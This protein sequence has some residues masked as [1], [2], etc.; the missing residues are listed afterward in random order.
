MATSSGWWMYHGDPAHTGYV[1]SGSAIDAAALSGGK[2]G[3]LHTLNVGGSILSVPAVSDGFIY[4]GLANSRDFPGEQ[5]GTLLKIDLKSG[6]TVKRFPWKVELN[7]RDTHGFCGMGS[8]PTVLGDGKTGKVYFVG[9]NAKLYC[10]TTADLSLVWVTDLRNRDLKHNQPVKTFEPGTDINNEPPPAAGWSAPLVVNGRIYLGIGEGENPQLNSFVFCLDAAT[11]NVVWVFCTNQ[12]VCGQINQPNQ[13]PE[14]VVRDIT[15]PPGYTVYYG[16][17]LTLGCSVWGCIAYDEKLNR[18]FCPTGNGVPDGRLPTPGWSNGLL[19][20]DATT[21]AF[22]AFYQIPRGSNYRDSDIDVD[23]GA[24]PTLF[25]LDGRRVVGVG[26]KNGSFHLLDADT[27]APIKCR[28]LLPTYNDGTQIPTVDPHP[29]KK[30]TDTNVQ[31]PR[32]AN[33]RSDLDDGEN[34]SGIYSTAAIHPGSR[35]IFVGIG[36]N[37]YHPVAAGIDTD[38]TPFIRALDYNTLDDAWPVD[39]GNPPRYAKGRP[40]LYTNSSESGLSSPAVVND[41]VFMATTYVSLYA[42]SVSDGTLLF[43]DRLGEQTGGFNGGYGYC[44]G[45]AVCGNYV[46]AGA[47]VFGGDGGVLRIYGITDGSGGVST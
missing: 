13:L 32:I 47:L 45:P 5:G 7:E 21:G 35:K 1:G 29:D 4:V 25:D 20:L 17:P 40:P 36:G 2:F 15:L 26:C 31:N 18:L 19:T 38:N 12:Y 16:T 34:Y 41:V 10:L 44:M 24:S 42:F 46:V 9:F 23:V 11:G 8:T 37:N 30:Q 27:L 33:R 43:E 6:Q 14:K 22:K 39:Q 28:Q 3:V